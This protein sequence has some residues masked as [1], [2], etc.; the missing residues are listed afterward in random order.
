LMKEKK[1]SATEPN[2]FA[3][4]GI[5]IIPQARSSYQ[6]E[7]GKHKFTARAI[8]NDLGHDEKKVVWTMDQDGIPA[9]VSVDSND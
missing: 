9:C 3:R 5:I 6:I 7:S 1:V 4:I 2:S 8:S